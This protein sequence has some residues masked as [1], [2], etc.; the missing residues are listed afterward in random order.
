MPMRGQ[1]ANDLIIHIIQGM[2][3]SFSGHLLCAKTIFY[4]CLLD[5]F[6]VVYRTTGPAPLQRKAYLHCNEGCD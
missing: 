6:I 3:V 2:F 4:M 1:W 5:I